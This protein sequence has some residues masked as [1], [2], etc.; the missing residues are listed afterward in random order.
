[1]TSTFR[2]DA[3]SGGSPTHQTLSPGSRDELA[4]ACGADAVDDEHDRLIHT[5]GN[6][7]LNGYN[8]SLGNGTFDKKR[9]V[10]GASSIRMNQRI[11]KEAAWGPDP[12]TAR[13]RFLAQQ[14]MAAWPGPVAAITLNYEVDRLI[15]NDYLGFD[16]SRDALSALVKAH[17]ITHHLLFA[18]RTRVRGRPLL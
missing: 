4:A 7:T 13:G 1:V 15:Q 16:A 9:P 8:E 17:L 5:L 12:I 3:E 2:N 18:H 6:L 11:A 14:V 10:L